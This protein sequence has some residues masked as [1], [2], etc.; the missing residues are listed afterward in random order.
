MIIRRNLVIAMQKRHMG[1]ELCCHPINTSCHATDDHM[2]NDNVSLFY[3]SNF[4]GE[5]TKVSMNAIEVAPSVFD[6][7][8][9]LILGGET[10]HKASIA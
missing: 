6:H 7:F 1:W 10:L 3:S 2:M 8:L 5:I 4:Y 9:L